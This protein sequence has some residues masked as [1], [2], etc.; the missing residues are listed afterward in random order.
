[1]AVKPLSW[2]CNMSCRTTIGLPIQIP[3]KSYE[4]SAW[5][6]VKPYLCWNSFFIELNLIHKHTLD[7]LKFDMRKIQGLDI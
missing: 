2:K 3:V 6:P 7:T 1:M 4:Q 5:L